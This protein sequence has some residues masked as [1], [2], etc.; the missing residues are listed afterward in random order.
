[1]RPD[2]PK[3]DKRKHQELELEGSDLNPKKQHPKIPK[4]QRSEQ[5]EPRFQL[6]LYHGYKRLAMGNMDRLIQ[7]T[8]GAAFL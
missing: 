4:I 7:V 5:H 6:Q 3:E 8:A 1:M 2:F